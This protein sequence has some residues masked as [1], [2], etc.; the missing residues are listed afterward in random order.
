MWRLHFQLVNMNANYQLLANFWAS[1][2][3]ISQILSG[4]RYTTG[5][6]ENTSCPTSAGRRASLCKSKP[7]SIPDIMMVILVKQF[8]FEVITPKVALLLSC[9]AQSDVWQ[10]L[11]T[12]P[13]SWATFQVMMGIISLWAYSKCTHHPPAVTLDH[14][15]LDWFALF[16][17][18][19]I[20][21]QDLLENVCWALWWMWMGLFCC[22]WCNQAFGRFSQA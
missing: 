15:L 13:P 18:M 11:S 17:L 3:N 6:M 19:H 1:R 5:S 4:N 10:K 9:K 2:D 7:F 16:R 8:N 20:H 22:L 21:L 12:E 14:L